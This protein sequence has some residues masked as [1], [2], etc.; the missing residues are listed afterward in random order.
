VERP[1]AASAEI[2]AEQHGSQLQ[3][4]QVAS[5]EFD[6]S[7]AER[8]TGT[9]LVELDDP[10]LSQSESSL[11]EVAEPH[12]QP[13]SPVERLLDEMSDIWMGA[14][15]CSVRSGDLYDIEYVDDGSREC[16]VEGCELRPRRTR[17]DL[18]SE[19][20]ERV[21]S[22]LHDKR[23]L[24]TFEALARMPCEAA[25]QE[26]QLWWC[27][28]YHE[29]F[30]RCSPRC[31]FERIVGAH[32]RI[33]AAKEVATC[34]SRA[35]EGLTNADKVPWK[36]RYIEQERLSDPDLKLLESYANSA[37][38]P[39]DTAYTV[40]GKKVTYGNSLSGMY[41]DPRLGRMVREC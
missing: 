13:G 22:C 5:E 40:S 39:G 24:C 8:H 31:C 16:E 1:P 32:G 20:W 4:S 30:G 6:Q 21:G 15:V 17:L 18:P 35:A 25:R 26:S 29:R 2:V 12:W 27:T 34:R 38:T 41:F 37:A 7:S 28:S 33:G 9:H 23:D 3:D 36:T 14:V 19:V 10:L 11:Q